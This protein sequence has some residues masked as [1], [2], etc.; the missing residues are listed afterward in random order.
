MGSAAAGA[1]K[2]PNRRGAARRGRA[3]AHVA[4]AASSSSCAWRSWRRGAGERPGP[5]ARAP[6][7]MA[8]LDDVASSRVRQL[9]HPS[10]TVDTLGPTARSRSTGGQSYM[11]KSM[12]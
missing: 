7:K 2:A 1:A 8:P 12:L 5:S 10:E 9:P 4:P 11:L 6:R 3:R